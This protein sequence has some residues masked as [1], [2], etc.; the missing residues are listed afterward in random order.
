MVAALSLP[1]LVSVLTPSY[2]YGRF[3]EDAIL[4]VAG[5][6]DVQTEH[7]IRDGGSTDETLAVLRAHEGRLSWQSRPD[8]GQSDALNQ[9]LSDAQ[10]R[11]IGWLNADEFYLPGGLAAL[12]QEGARSGADVVY[13][14]VAFVD[15][16]GRLLRLVPQHPFD[17]FVL[18]WYGNFIASAATVFRRHRLG[19]EPWNIRCRMVMDWDLLVRL[20][21]A[22]AK[23]SYVPRVVG[24][25]RVHG[26]R[27][28]ARPR[29]EFLEELT[30]F[31][32]RHRLPP[33]SFRPVGQIVHAARKLQSGAYLR[34]IRARPLHGQ[35][36]RWFRPEVGLG[37]WGALE[38][39]SR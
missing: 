23:F 14:D 21:K 9:A 29:S 35:D 11:W 5:Q 19:I 25:F 26:A 30:S 31:R 36:M 18:R 39:T 22:G 24:A 33:R 37:S 4:S 2:A 16:V 27:V 17:A 12:V 7:I 28:T 32:H 1:E 13:G 38:R 15:E 6:T 10:G 3:I 34:Q 20:M 8:R